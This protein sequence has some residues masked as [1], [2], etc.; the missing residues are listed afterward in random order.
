MDPVGEAARDAVGPHHHDRDR[1]RGGP[2]RRWAAT[3]LPCTQSFL[4]RW[5][6][7]AE[8]PKPVAI[9]DWYRTPLPSDLFKKLHQRS[10][11]RAFVQS[12]GF[13]A[14]AATTGTLTF[15]SWGHWPWYAT[16]LCFFLHG[17]V[18]HFYVNGMHELGHGTVFRTK[19]L[20]AVFRALTISSLAIPITRSI[21]GARRVS[22][23]N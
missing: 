7:M 4:T 16:V 19:W 5:G 22:A 2:A 3:C 17:T 15:W 6:N 23:Y 21:S 12:S 20:N 9:V 13:L 11:G 8:T 10:D 18:S 14:I 1:G